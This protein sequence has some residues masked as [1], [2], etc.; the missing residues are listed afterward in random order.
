MDGEGHFSIRRSVLKGNKPQYSPRIGIT[1][2]NAAILTRSRQI[3]DA[4]NIGYYFR[5][6]GQG[7]FDGSKKQVWVIAV[8]TMVNAVRLIIAVKP[9][10][11]GKL[12]QAECILEYCNKRLLVFKNGRKG[13]TNKDKQ[14]APEDFDLIRKVFD[15]N[16]DI[17]GTSETIR[18]D[19]QRAMI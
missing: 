13:L 8:E 9:Y 14:Y 11:I 3:M 10:L 15:A 6:K 4:L 1:N 12:F 16:G 7:D 5:E 2:T 17:R 19:A 18:Q